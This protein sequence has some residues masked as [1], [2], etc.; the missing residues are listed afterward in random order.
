MAETTASLAATLTE[1]AAG[2]ELLRTAVAGL[3]PEQT[4]ARPVTGKWSVHEVVCHLS[5]CEFL[6]AD[7]MKRVLA[8]DKPTLLGLDP[9]VHVPR[10]ALPERD[11]GEELALVELVRKQLARILA[12]VPAADFQRVGIHSESGPLTLETL[13]S[14]VT[15]HIPHH[16]KFIEEKRK[17]LGV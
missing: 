12:T 2:P 4:R 16:V 5:D 11:I 8:E 3:T 6:Y 9:D 10:L 17:A 15:K 13:L 7:R 14:R 1:Y